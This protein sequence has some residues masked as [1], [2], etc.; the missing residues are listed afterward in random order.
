MIEN[1]NNLKTVK[2]IKTIVILHVRGQ[3][4]SGLMSLKMAACSEEC[5]Y[6]YMTESLHYTADV[7][8]TL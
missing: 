7:G 6:V 1:W 3:S 8:T 2:K 4:L 5:L